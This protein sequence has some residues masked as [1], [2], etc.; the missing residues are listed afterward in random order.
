MASI[1]IHGKE[2]PL[3]DSF[4]MGELADM[5][6][7]TGQG[8]DLGKPG[9]RGMLAM[10]YIAARRKDPT[11]TVDDI[12]SIA[13]DQIE[14]ED[15]EVVEPVSPEKRG[16]DAANTSSSDDSSGNG[17]EPTPDVTLDR[18]GARA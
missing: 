10:A 5:E 8:Y 12:R 14:M 13:I 1:K 7:I 6:E 15:D 16:D 4:T 2:Y 18:I 11:V 17:S 3:P 9:I